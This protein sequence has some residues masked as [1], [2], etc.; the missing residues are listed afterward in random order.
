MLRVF[1]KAFQDLTEGPSGLKSRGG[2]RCRDTA[3]GDA[4]DLATY[5]GA[6]QEDFDGVAGDTC[7]EF[8]K[9]KQ[10]GT[11]LCISASLPGQIQDAS[12]AFQWEDSTAK[13]RLLLLLQEDRSASV[14]PLTCRLTHSGLGE[15]LQSATQGG[16]RSKTATWHLP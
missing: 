3:V 16:C 13:I 15:P 8:E 12:A 11:G 1:H 7:N 4:V 10:A 6:W 9:W 2:D 14:R 5:L